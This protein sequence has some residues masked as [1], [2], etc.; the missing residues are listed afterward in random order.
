V[1]GIK[2]MVPQG[3]IK[4]SNLKQLPKSKQGIRRSLFRNFYN[5]YYVNAGFAEGEENYAG[6]P[7]V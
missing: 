6:Q 7:S 4:L 5:S 2:K 1:T 3:N